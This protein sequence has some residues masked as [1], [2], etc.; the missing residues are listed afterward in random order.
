MLP[1]GDGIESEPFRLYNLDVFEY[2][3]DS[4]FGLYGSVPYVISHKPDATVGAF[5]CDSARNSALIVHCVHRHQ[6]TYKPV[7]AAAQQSMHH[8]LLVA[9]CAV[10]ATHTGCKSTT[11]QEL[12]ASR[13]DHP[14]P[15][16]HR[17]LKLCRHNAAEML[18][19]VSQPSGGMSTRWIAD[20]GILDLFLLLG[21]KPADVMAQYARLTGPT[22]MP[23]VRYGGCLC[24]A[25]S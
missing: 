7:S 8:P 10:R 4:P 11:V 16:Q 18:V 5:W 23:Q 22:A 1:A 21:P 19:D 12:Q 14:V 9:C 24:A 2:E 6:P 15:H 20:S 17:R 3:H 25:V 13:P